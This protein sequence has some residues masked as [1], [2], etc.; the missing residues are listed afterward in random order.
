MSRLWT[1]VVCVLL[2][3]VA[4][5]A[6][7]LSTSVARG[8]VPSHD[9][10][11]IAHSGPVRL[12]VITSTPVEKARQDSSRRYILDYEITR[13]VSLPDSLRRAIRHALGDSASYISGG[14]SRQC[15]FMPVY[16]LRLGRQYLALISTGN[17]SRV[18]LYCRRS[19]KTVFCDLVDNSPVEQVLKKVGL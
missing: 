16:A 7:L 15:E 4:L 12:F 3:A 5:S 8:Q 17:C 14:N 2:S 19:G 18:G 1:L 9:R 11:S 10:R 6:L 13:L